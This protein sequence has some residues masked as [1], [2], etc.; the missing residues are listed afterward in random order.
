MTDLAGAAW[1]KSSRSGNNG[2]I[3]VAGAL[4]GA[5]ELVGVRDSKDV[6]GPT[7]LFGMTA[8]RAFLVGLR[9]DD[10]PH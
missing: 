7:L 1:R 9:A 6:D 2:C 5:P 4:P 8:W 3:E 10:L